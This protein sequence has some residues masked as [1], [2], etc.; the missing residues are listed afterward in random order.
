MSVYHFRAQAIIGPAVNCTSGYREADTAGEKQACYIDSPVGSKIEI[1]CLGRN[2]IKIHC[3]GNSRRLECGGVFISKTKDAEIILD[4]QETRVLIAWPEIAT[5]E[6]IPRSMSRSSSVDSLEEDAENSNPRVART[7]LSRNKISSRCPDSPTPRRKSGN[8]MIF[9]S[10]SGLD[11]DT[12]LEIYKDEFAE[13]CDEIQLPEP[14]SSP[15]RDADY[16]AKDKK[17]SDPILQRF[18]PITQSFD[19]S[20]SLLPP[21][22]TITAE[23]LASSPSRV[24]YWRNRRRVEA[25]PEAQSRSASL[26]PN[27]MNTIQNR[28]TNQLASSRLSSTQLSTPGRTRIKS[29]MRLSRKEW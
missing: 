19:G 26:S 7:R 25:S 13:N 29:G 17:V 16:E 18:D 3:E 2:A 4:I 9:P 24:A 8:A 5:A 21:L 11:T 12:Q 22:A 23:A 10:E 14:P 27:K 28:L 1:E 20:E 6:A 15:G